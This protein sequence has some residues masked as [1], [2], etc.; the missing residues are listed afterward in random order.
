MAKFQKIQLQISILKFLRIFL[1]KV[2]SQASQTQSLKNVQNLKS[3]QTIEMKLFTSQASRSKKEKLFSA[4]K[5]AN[6]L[7]EANE[8]AREALRFDAMTPHKDRKL[9]NEFRREMQECVNQ[10]NI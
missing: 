2:Q 5:Q 6:R 8:V 10:T 4:L 1:L 7:V 9:Q 3:V